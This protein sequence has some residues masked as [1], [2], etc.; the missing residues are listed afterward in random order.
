MAEVA[1][2]DKRLQEFDFGELIARAE[3]QH[4]ETEE[5]RL[6]CAQSVFRRLS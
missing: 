6:A 5:K 2:S 1:V 4:A 3:K